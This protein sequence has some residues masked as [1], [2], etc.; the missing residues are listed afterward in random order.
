MIWLELK[1]DPA[2]RPGGGLVKNGVAEGTR[3]PGLQGHNLAL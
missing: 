1:V 2:R 3:T